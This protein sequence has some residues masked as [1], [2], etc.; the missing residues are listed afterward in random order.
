MG[1]GDAGD[2]PATV[3]QLNAGA[4]RFL[5]SPGAGSIQHVP[6]TGGGFHLVTTG[7][8]AAR[9]EHQASARAQKNRTTRRIMGF[10]NSRRF[11]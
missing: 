11:A 9:N 8:A 3:L 1:N 5:P 10:G 6:P 2:G 7:W 4:L